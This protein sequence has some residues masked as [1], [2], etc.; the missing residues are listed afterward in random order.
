MAM[1][2]SCIDC[3]LLLLDATQPVGIEAPSHRQPGSGSS[4]A[5][6]LKGVRLKERGI[7]IDGRDGLVKMLEFIPVVGS[8]TMK[9]KYWKVVALVANVSSRVAT[10]LAQQTRG[11]VLRVALD[12]DQ[13]AVAELLGGDTPADIV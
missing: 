1:V 5:H 3:V 6:V 11:L 2:S 9:R 12:E 7:A 13:V 10:V 4:S 8:H